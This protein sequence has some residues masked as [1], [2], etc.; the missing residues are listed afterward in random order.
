MEHICH[1]LRLFP[2]TEQEY[3][4]LHALIPAELSAAIRESGI[5]NYTGFRR[6]TDVWYYAECEPDARTAFARSATTEASA[7]WNAAF[8]TIVAEIRGQD[9]D[10][11]WY[12]RFSAGDEPPLTGPFERAILSSVIHPKIVADYLSLQANIWPELREAIVHS[13]I[14]NYQGF[15]RGG[16]VIY[17]GEFYPD[18]RSCDLR[19]SAT[20]AYQVWAKS[21]DGILGPTADGSPMDVEIREIFHQD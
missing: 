7:H 3:D 4:R 21:L 11:L 20:D 6:G 9:G 5:R 13:G 2:G 10:L 17:Y 15:R 12:E 1:Y 8:E 18:R 19:L 14:R 16:H